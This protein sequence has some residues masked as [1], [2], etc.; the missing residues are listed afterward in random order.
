[1]PQLQQGQVTPGQ[2]GA[3]RVY[4]VDKVE[5]SL[6]FQER[7]SR[8]FKP[9]EFVTV[10]NID[11]KPVY[12]QYMP[13]E[14]EHENFSEDGMQK[15]I[16]RETP[17]MWV[18]MPGQTEVIVGASAYRALDVMYKNYTAKKT[19]KRFNDPDS[20]QFDENGKHMPKNFNYADGG[21]QQAFLDQAYIG[22]ATPTFTAV[23]EPVAAPDAQQIADG[24][25]A[26][27]S[28]PSEP[29]VNPDAPVPRTTEGAPLEQP[30]YADP[31][32]VLPK[33]KS[34]KELQG[35]KK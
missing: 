32:A 35:A 4:G 10:K 33:V 2:D 25:H 8:L 1:M 17:E 31:N 11:D 26:P 7:M 6:P 24:P 27:V 16:T 14:N 30:T 12:W 21:Q 19:L 28:Q 5:N 23:Q 22:K 29:V 20:P 15:M 18:I 13:I 3:P 34:M 9:Q